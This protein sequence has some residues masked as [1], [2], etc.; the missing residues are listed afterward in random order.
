MVME[1]SWVKLVGGWWGAAQL[2][3]GFQKQ[4]RPAAL[5]WRAVDPG[6]TVRRG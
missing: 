5:R 4:K 1:L 6:K 3:E 2:E